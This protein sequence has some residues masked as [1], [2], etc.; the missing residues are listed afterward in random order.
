MNA[1]DR[2][3]SADMKAVA[4][5]EDRM[6]DLDLLDSERLRINEVYTRLGEYLG[7]PREMAAFQR[8]VHDRFA[9]I[10]FRVRCDFYEDVSED[11]L[12]G[13]Q[14]PSITIEG[15]I[16]DPGEFD[17]DQM[18]YEVRSNLLGLNKQGAVQKTQ[19]GQTGFGRTKSGLIVPD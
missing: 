14:Y 5:A 10:G 7:Q 11:H 3:R 19:I 6:Q 4:D 18:G 8:E 2:F 13:V 12:T 16:E 9:E 15:R 17:H 1:T